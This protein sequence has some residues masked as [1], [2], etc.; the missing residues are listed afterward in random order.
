MDG[1]QTAKKSP[2]HVPRFAWVKTGNLFVKHPGRNLMEPLSVSRSL[3]S[4]FV[5]GWIVD[6]DTTRR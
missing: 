6:G 1:G 3:V 5:V 2:L 4:F